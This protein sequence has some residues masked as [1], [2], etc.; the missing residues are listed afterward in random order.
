MG[1]FGGSAIDGSM[2]QVGYAT[3]YQ[4]PCEVSE[5]LATATVKDD[6]F[7]LGSVLYEVST[8]VRLFADITSRDI[9]TRFRRRAYPDLDSVTDSRI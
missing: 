5:K 6:L 2:A 3:R 9:Q 7:A 1:D 8:G 4:R